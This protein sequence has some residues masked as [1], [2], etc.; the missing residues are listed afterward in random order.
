MSATAVS[1]LDAVLLGRIQFAFT[2]ALH[3][4]FPAFTIGLASWLVVLE[5]S[6]LRTGDR[7][8]RRLYLFW[9]TIFALSFGMGVVSGIVMSYQFGTNWSEF[10]RLT[11]PVLGPLLS[12]EVL[13]AFFLEAGFLGIMLFGW[14][15]VPRPLHFAAT[16]LVA[17]GTL[18]SAFWILS[19]NSW[20]Q[21]PQGHVITA[22]GVFY[23]ASWWDIVFNPSFPYRLVHMVVAAFLTT[24]FAVAAVGAW[25]LLRRPGDPAARKTL[26]MALWFA[27]IAA[28]AQVAAGDMHGLNTLEHQPAKIAAMEG[29]FETREGAPLILFGW[30]DMDAGETRWAVEIPKLGSLILTHSW[31]G[32]VQ[33][34][35]D[36]PEQ[37]RPPAPIVFWSFRVMVG[38]G[39]IMV[40][41]ALWGTWLR[42]R[43][44][45]TTS[46][47]F[48]KT[49][50]VC[51]PIGFV[52]LLAGWITTEVGRQPWLVYGLLRTA[53]G[54]SPVPGASVATSLAVFVVVY[55]AVFGAGTYYILRLMAKGPRGP[56]PEPTTHQAQTSWRPLSGAGESYDEGGER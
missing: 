53:D 43:G 30:P 41:M 36:W 11:G 52:A 51:G 27:L 4:L 32:R 46:R 56:E 19:A 49:V 39:F 18:I 16:C 3:I 37:D 29:H 10:S 13:T 31:N 5:A 8:Y 44:H 38:L 17:I 28:P 23:P 42:W 25:H 20:M 34:L 50:V 24:S 7:V 14:D 40:G 55:L 2:I 35:N 22:D 6:W 21:T 15:R 9:S 12:Y 45:L 48:L 47:G 54:A 1:A 33:G 26:S